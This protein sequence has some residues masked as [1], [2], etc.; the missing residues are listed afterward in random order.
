MLLEYSSGITVV[1]ANLVN[2]LKKDLLPLISPDEDK[3]F[4]QRHCIV[5]TATE[6]R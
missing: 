2:V 5:L 6:T 4:P 1:E 3:E